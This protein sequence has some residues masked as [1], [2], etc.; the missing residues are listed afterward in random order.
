[1]WRSKNYGGKGFSFLSCLTNLRGP[2]FKSCISPLNY[3]SGKLSDAYGIPKEAW[4]IS[5]STIRVGPC[6]EH[7]FMERQ[8]NMKQ[9][10]F[11]NRG[12]NFRQNYFP[13][14]IDF[15]SNCK[16]FWFILVSFL[17]IYLLNN[18]SIAV[19]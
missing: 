15:A 10:D 3:M 17:F 13:L 18:V 6:T 8:I 12:S 5:L 4:V 1:M 14:V 11:L 16:K 2:L 19:S 7:T 9:T